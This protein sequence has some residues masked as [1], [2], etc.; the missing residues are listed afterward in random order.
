VNYSKAHTSSP[1]SCCAN[2][3]TRPPDLANCAVFLPANAAAAAAKLQNLPER[4]LVQLVAYYS[5]GP[6]S[7]DGFAVLTL[8]QVADKLAAVFTSTDSVSR[9]LRALVARGVLDRKQFGARLHGYRIAEQLQTSF[10]ATQRGTVDRVRYQCLTHE[11]AR[12]LDLVGATGAQ[13]LARHLFR[14]S[15]RLD[16]VERTAAQLQTLL[17]ATLPTEHA[18]RMAVRNLEAA[19][20]VL[21]TRGNRATRFYLTKRGAELA[22]VYE[23]G[24]SF[25]RPTAFEFDQAT[26][27]GGARVAKMSDDSPARLAKIRRNPVPTCENPVPK[28]RDSTQEHQTTRDDRACARAASTESA[29]PSHDVTTEPREPESMTDTPNRYWPPRPSAVTMKRRNIWPDG[30]AEFIEA[31]GGFTLWRAKFKTVGR[32]TIAGYLREFPQIVEQPGEYGAIARWCIEDGQFDR[33]PYGDKCNTLTLLENVA[34]FEDPVA[35]LAALKRESAATLTPL[36]RFESSTRADGPTLLWRG[37]SQHYPKRANLE[38]AAVALAGWCDRNFPSK[39][40]AAE[41]LRSTR[42]R[43]RSCSSLHN[44]QYWPSLEKWIADERWLQ[45]INHDHNARAPEN[46]RARFAQPW[47]GEEFEQ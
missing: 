36:A 2:R 21:T 35:D 11:H 16:K 20:V 33:G 19:G 47:P 6:R 31:A 15:A 27:T 32:G 34:C 40:A 14:I 1:T 10:P 39:A 17:P 24:E 18:A 30:W 44:P 8:S 29:R 41:I 22:A 4:A 43:F 3:D 25:Q 28:E 13:T 37:L 9:N 12:A 46:V 45:M 38:A 23:P 7:R 5:R 26:G 42:E